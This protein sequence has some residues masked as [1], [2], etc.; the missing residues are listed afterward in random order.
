MSYDTNLHNTVESAIRIIKERISVE[1]AQKEADR[2]AGTYDEAMR[3][4]GRKEAYE[5]VLRLFAEP[6]RECGQPSLKSL[7]SIMQLCG[8]CYDRQERRLAMRDDE[9]ELAS[10][11][12]P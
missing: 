12:R 1:V 11:A 4:Q 3:H 2:N 7:G 10:E 8:D 5:H 6:C 9:V